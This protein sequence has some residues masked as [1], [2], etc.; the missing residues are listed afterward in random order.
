MAQAA[1]EGGSPCG[2]AGRVEDVVE[3]EQ[4]GGVRYVADRG[5]AVPDQAGRGVL[6]DLVGVLRLPGEHGQAQPVVTGVV[7]RAVLAA[8]V[9][10]RGLAQLL[11]RG[12]VGGTA[13]QGGQA[14]QRLIGGGDRHENDP[15]PWV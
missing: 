12:A 1:F 4:S 11:E 15:L 8:V 10:L 14:G 5:G 7:Q 13:G 3:A 9:R 6:G 2:E